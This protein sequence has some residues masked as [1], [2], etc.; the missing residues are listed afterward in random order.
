MKFSRA[1]SIMN[2]V[3]AEACVLHQGDAGKITE[4]LGKS[5]QKFLKS[6]EY[7]QLSLPQ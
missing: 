5:S 1:A 6:N 7:R 3:D 2:I 4:F